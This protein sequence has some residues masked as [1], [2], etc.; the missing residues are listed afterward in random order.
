VILDSITHTARRDHR[1]AFCGLT[2]QAGQQYVR[3]QYPGGGR[4]EK[5]AF[6]SKC[7]TRLAASARKTNSAKE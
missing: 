5:R 1:F 6:H 2:I 3:A 7:Y 4:L